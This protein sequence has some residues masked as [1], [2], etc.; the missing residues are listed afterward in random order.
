[1]KHI[2]IGAGIL[3]AATAYSLVQQ[4]EDVVLVDADFRGKATKAGAGIVCP[5]VGAR[6]DPDLYELAKVSAID[7]PA[8]IDDLRADEA[9][10]TGYYK[11]GALALANTESELEALYEEAVRKRKET[12]FVGDVEKLT[13]SEARKMFPP[14][15][16]DCSAVYVSGGARVDGDLLTQALVRAFVNRGGQLLEEEVELESRGDEVFVR[17][18]DGVL[19]ADQVIVSAGAWSKKLLEQ[20]D[21]SIVL[22]PQRGQIAHLRAEGEDT[23]DWPVVL[24]QSSH[25]MLAFDDGRVVFGATR[26]ADSGFDYRLTAGGV[27][28]VLDE[29]LA[30]AP[31]LA[32]AT[33]EEV[34]IGFRPMGPD[35]KPLLGK[36]SSYSNLIVATGLGPSGLTIGPFVGKMTAK[37]AIDEEV[38]MDLTPFDPLR[39]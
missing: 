8:L 38:G 10:V 33:L 25:Y 24:P 5:W 21:V 12:D 6:K 32:D 17:T 1:M 13:N 4:G 22:E 34:R 2:I 3:G 27:Q 7:Y 37:L 15:Q 9:G 23:K 36:I 16:N 18:R 39:T 31:G 14:L 19:D 20:V 35:Q 30:V 28:E 26:E 29:G 11:C